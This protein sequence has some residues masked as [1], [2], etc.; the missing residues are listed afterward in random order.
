MRAAVPVVV[1]CTSRIPS[2]N[3]TIPYM[4][5]TIHPMIGPA[6]ELVNPGVGDGSKSRFE[7][8]VSGPHKEQHEQV[9]D[10]RA[11]NQAYRRIDRRKD[12]VEYEAPYTSRKRLAG[13][14]RS[15]EQRGKD[16]AENAAKQGRDQSADHR[17]DC[18]IYEVA[19]S[20]YAPEEGNRTGQDRHNRS[21]EAADGIG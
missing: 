21:G 15:G 10:A 12:K 11:Y 14:T 19:P 2:T 3:S 7:T 9:E 1:V 5:P 16:K 4:G 17:E 6:Y 8:R 20:C 13:V 18:R